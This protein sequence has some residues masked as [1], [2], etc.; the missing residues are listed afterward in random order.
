MCQIT[1]K[2]SP[3]ISNEALNE[4]FFAAW[5]NHKDW[6]FQPVLSRS[7]AYICAYQGE[8]LVGFVNVA[9]DGSQHAFILDTTV[10]PE[11][12]RQGIGT[13]MLQVAAEV[14]R[15]HRIEWL[16]VDYEP[17]L[18][19]FYHKAGFRPTKAGLMWLGGT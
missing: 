5:K 8:R 12:Q 13:A 7:L 6:D 4:L 2:T 14:C 19:T 16:H 1:Y 10:H 17:H 11:F 3:P 18:E 15:E 9:W